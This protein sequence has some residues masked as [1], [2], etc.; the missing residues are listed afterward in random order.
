MWLR[1]SSTYMIMVGSLVWSLL[2][3]VP[4]VISFMSQVYLSWPTIHP[5]LCC[6]VIWDTDILL[7]YLDSLDNTCL[8]F[9]LLS[10]KT[11][12]LLT[13]LSGQRVS[14]IH[15]IGLSQLQLTTDMA[16]FYLGATLLKHSRLGRSNPPLCFHRYPHGCRLCPLQAIRDYV[17]Q[18]TF[19]APQID[20]FFIT[21]CK[22]YHPASKGYLSQVGQGYAPFKWSWYITLSCP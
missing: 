12:T 6:V 8:D 1:F 7:P 21:H 18:R 4:W 14:T 11:A 17:M 16:I 9:K 10:C 2:L 20:K 5:A 19:L 3:G 15:A 22:P 13:I